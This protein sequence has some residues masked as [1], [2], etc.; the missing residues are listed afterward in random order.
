[1]GDIVAFSADAR[2]SPR[3]GVE[4]RAFDD[5]AVLVDITTG[6][7]FELNRIGFEVWQALGQGTSISGICETLHDRYGVEPGTLATDIDNL[8]ASLIEARLLVAAV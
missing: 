7:C 5:G 3:P 6:A 1:M 4:S 8:V 2:F